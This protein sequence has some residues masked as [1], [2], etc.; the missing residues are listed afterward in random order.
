M[1]GLGYYLFR[2]TLLYLTRVILSGTGSR[3]LVV[4]YMTGDNL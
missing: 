4:D 3:P 1:I 2:F